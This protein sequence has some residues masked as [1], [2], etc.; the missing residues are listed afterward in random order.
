MIGKPVEVEIVNRPSSDDDFDMDQIVYYEMGKSVTVPLAEVDTSKGSNHVFALAAE[1]V[2]IY[3]MTIRYSSELGEV[4][5]I[6][7]TIFTQSVP[8]GV[9]TFS[10]TNGEWKELKRRVCM[11]NKYSVLRLHFAQSG[12]KM[13]SFTMR[14]LEKGRDGNA[15]NGTSGDFELRFT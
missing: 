6:P 5:Q 9:L 11:T 15:E 13:E 10:G 14:L 2:G 8:I 7:V 1:D 12:V 4:A 3:E